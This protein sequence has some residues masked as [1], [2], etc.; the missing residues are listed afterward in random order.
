[1]SQD[2][3][4]P[5]SPGAVRA[6]ILLLAAVRVIDPA[7]EHQF[8]GAALDSRQGNLCQQGDGIVIQLAPAYG[9]EVAEQAGGIM[10]PAPPQVSGERPE[11]LP[12]RSDEPVESACLAHHRR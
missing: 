6:K 10:I 12:G 8:L 5:R 7:V 9:I 4:V 2:A 3:R 11:S 1:M